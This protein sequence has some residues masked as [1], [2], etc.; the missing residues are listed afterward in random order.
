MAV[1]LPRPGEVENDILKVSPDVE[2]AGAKLRSLVDADRLGV[3][4][5]LQTFQ[6]QHD[7]LDVGDPRVDVSAGDGTGD[8]WLEAVKEMSSSQRQR[9]FEI[10]MLEGAGHAVDLGGA[11]ADRLGCSPPGRSRGCH[12]FDYRAS[13]RQ[14]EREEL[15]RGFQQIE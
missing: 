1:G 15:R 13:L 10:V 14:R 4:D 9:S 7:I 12:F 5:V 3:V 6:C 11:G 8:G 2:I